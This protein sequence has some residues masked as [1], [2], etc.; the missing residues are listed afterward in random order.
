MISIVIRTKNE[1]RWITRCLKAIRSQTIQ[2]HEIVLVDN[3]SEDKTVERARKIYPDLTLL[4]IKEF[5]PGHAINE[6]IR[7]SKGEYL[8][9]LSAHCPPVDEYWLE[10]L[11][12]NL[13][14]STIAGVYGRQIPVSF[15]SPTD[16]RDLVLTFGLDR[17][18]QV[19]DTFFHNANSMFRREIWKKFPFDEEVSNIEDR[20][21]GK[22]VI[23]AGYKIVYEP[24]AAVYHHHGIHQENK[25]ERLRG[26]VR[27]MEDLEVESGIYDGN[28]LDPG[29]L[30]IACMIP[31]RWVNELDR[32]EMRFLIET[33]VGQARQSQ[34]IDRIFVLPDSEELAEMAIGCGAEVPFIRPEVYSAERVRVDE[35]LQ[36]SL[37]RLE[38]GGYFPE[39]IVPLEV[40]YPFRPKRMIDEIIRQITLQGLDTVMVSI[41]EQRPCWIKEKGGIRN[42][43]EYTKHKNEREPVHVGLI[44]VGCVT[45]PEFIREGSRIGR[46]LGLYEISNPIAAVEVSNKE[47]FKLVT[48]SYLKAE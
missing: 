11:K 30:E 15:S 32:E 41:E 7:A 22:Q 37:M 44:S 6:G 38:K 23:D 31:V 2:E 39:L 35:V 47:K 1:E 4:S 21:W 13:S 43:T 18:V 28:P 14:D 36:Y 3:N 5:K 25:K 27:I 17:R 8:V 46:E 48:E 19:K 10:N 12:K 42:I 45:Y 33:T 16:K 34:F 9:C 20:V 26:V 29:D 40:T 24:E